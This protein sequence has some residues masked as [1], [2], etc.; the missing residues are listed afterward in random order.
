MRAFYMPL[1]VPSFGGMHPRWLFRIDP[2]SARY[3]AA[4]ALLKDLKPAATPL[5]AAHRA[6]AR[7]ILNGQWS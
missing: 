3:L 1:G 7:G 6:V 2:T 5:A 4:E